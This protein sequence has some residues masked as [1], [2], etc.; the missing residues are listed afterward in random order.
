M[1]KYLQ[2][3][4]GINSVSIHITYQLDLPSPHPQIY[5]LQELRLLALFF[6]GSQSAVQR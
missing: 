3:H 1:A 2:A 5:H 6:A 4:Q